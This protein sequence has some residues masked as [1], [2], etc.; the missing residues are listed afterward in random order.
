MEIQYFNDYSPALNRNMEC[1]IY[2]HAGRPMLF[3]P[4][5]DGVF[6]DF[7]GY[8]MVD[9][10]APWINAGE[11][12]VISINTIDK[13]TW[14]DKFSDENY[15]IHL[16]EK[17]LRYITNEI[18]PKIQ[19][20]AKERNGW[21]QNPG[22]LV[23]GC[24]LGA[25]HA[26]NL[27]LRRPDLFDG[28]MALSGIYSGNFGFPNYQSER[29]YYNSPVDYMK[30][31]PLD[32]PY[33]DLYRNQRAVVCVGQGA[34]EETETSFKLKEIF[35]EKNIPIWVDIWGYDVNH[36]WSWWHKQVE[37]F[38]PYLMNY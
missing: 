17:W 5:Q 21:V 19:W 12:M 6:N 28:C 32:H 16:Y 23:F 18:V 30:N 36:D 29:V 20:L 10:L 3:I 4:C 2:G 26:L 31:F 22:V 7:E 34:W 24:S 38:M 25:T 9:T 27:Y 37:Y 13:E 1:K 8:H 15:R 11:L 14:S 35:A 33:M